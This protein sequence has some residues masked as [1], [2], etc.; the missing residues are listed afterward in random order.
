MQTQQQESNME[1]CAVTHENLSKDEE[2]GEIFNLYIPLPQ[3]AKSDARTS[4]IRLSVFKH[5]LRSAPFFLK[6][7]ISQ[8]PSSS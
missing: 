2:E 4:Q 1:S 8:R 6:A 7:L 5:F 3:P